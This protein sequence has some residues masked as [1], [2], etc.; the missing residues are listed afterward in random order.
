MLRDRKAAEVEALLAEAEV[1][2]AMVRNLAEITSHPQFDDRSLFAEAR[3]PGREE[4]ITLLG[5]GFELE[6]EKLEVG[7]IPTLGE[8]TDAVLATLGYDDAE[9][10]ALRAG[11]VV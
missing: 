11:G 10:A 5:A 7:A 3:M 4:P 6:G 2:V 1:P 9:I 8:H